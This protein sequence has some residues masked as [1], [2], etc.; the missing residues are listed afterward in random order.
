MT[1]NLYKKYSKYK[2]KYLNTKIMYGGSTIDDIDNILIK[3]FEHQ[4]QIKMLHFQTKNLNAHKIL[5]AHLI[6]F[7][8]QLDLFMEV[9]Q[10]ASDRVSLKKINMNINMIDDDISNKNIIKKLNSMIKNVYNKSM[11]TLNI[12]NN[13]SLLAIRDS[14]VEDA[15]QTIYLLSFK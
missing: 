2:N 7:S 12:D 3:L 15:Q 13:N 1:N 14:F 6:K 4:I 9:A 5:N 10:G 11:L 8:T